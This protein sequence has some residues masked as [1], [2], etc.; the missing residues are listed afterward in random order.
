MA[1]CMKL[2]YNSSEMCAMLRS[3]W[4]RS[5]EEAKCSQ[6]AYKV[7]KAERTWEILKDAVVRKHTDQTQCCKK[8]NLP[9]PNI[10]SH[11][12]GQVVWSCAE[13]KA[14]ILVQQGVLQQRSSLYNDVKQ[15]MPPPPKKKNC[16]SIGTSLIRLIWLFR[17]LKSTFKGW[18]FRTSTALKIVK[19]ALHVIPKNMTY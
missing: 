8:C 9:C 4:A 16:H 19:S 14:W 18:Y 11:N 17:Q 15:F 12:N 6:I 7:Q 1:H 10:A 5:Y 13:K 3:I 2:W